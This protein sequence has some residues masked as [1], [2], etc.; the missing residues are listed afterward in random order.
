MVTLSTAAST[1]L[2]PEASA[3]SIRMRSDWPA[4]GVRLRLA[5]VQ[6]PL[7]LVAAPGWVSRAVVPA[8]VHHADPQVARRRAGEPA[9]DQVGGAGVRGELLG[10]RG[11]GRLGGAPLPRAEGGGVGACRVGGPAGGGLEGVRPD[12]AAAATDA[13]LRLL[14]DGPVRAVGVLAEQ[15][16]LGCGWSARGSPRRAGRSRRRWTTPGT[17]RRCRPR[18]RG[19]PT[20]SRCWCRPRCRG[21]WTAPGYSCWWPPSAGRSW[22]R[23]CTGP[24]SSRRGCSRWCSRTARAPAASRCGSRCWP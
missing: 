5:S 8:V 24:R 18:S 16:N 17:S 1:R 21:R 11:G 10:A 14:A 19:W 4:Y 9:G 20:S 6:L 2:A 23:R 22:R 7:R 13:V 12:R 15:Q 3:A